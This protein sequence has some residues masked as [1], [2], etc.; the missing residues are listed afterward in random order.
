MCYIEVVG[1]RWAPDPHICKV[2]T[3][4]ENIEII[5]FYTSCVSHVDTYDVK[6]ESVAT[7]NG[8]WFLRC[9]SM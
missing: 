5:V 6:Q 2:R 3:L 1:P 4:L 9:V 8:I 7:A